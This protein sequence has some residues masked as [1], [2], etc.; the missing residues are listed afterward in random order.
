MPERARVYETD[1]WIPMNAAADALPRNRRQLNVIA[2][3]AP[4]ATLR[5]VNTELGTSRS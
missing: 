1:L 5:D 4:G 2:R 3:I